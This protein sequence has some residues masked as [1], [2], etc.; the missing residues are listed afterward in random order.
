[1][2][3]VT[4]TVGESTAI[5]PHDRPWFDVED[6]ARRYKTSVRHIYRLADSR[7]MPW[8]AKLG[9]LRRWSRQAIEEWEARACTPLDQTPSAEERTQ[10]DKGQD[11][12]QLRHAEQA[13]KTD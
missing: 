6:L 11:D 13:Q 10:P 4:N 9:H 5:P 2:E 7:R 3:A 8:G 1:M 12:G